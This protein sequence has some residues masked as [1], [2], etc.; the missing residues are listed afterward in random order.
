MHP[1]AA[2]RLEQ[3]GAA[4]LTD[5]NC[6]RLASALE[7][8]EN[9]KR[10]FMTAHERWMIFRWSHS[11][12]ARCGSATSASRFLI[13]CHRFARHDGIPPSHAAPVG[14][15]LRRVLRVAE[16]SAGITS[17]RY[18]HHRAELCESCNLRLAIGRRRCGTAR[19]RLLVPEHCQDLLDPPHACLGLL[20][21][22]AASPCVQPTRGNQLSTLS[23]WPEEDGTNRP[24]GAER[25]RGPGESPLGPAEGC[26]VM[27]GERGWPGPC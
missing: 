24:V 14:R 10:A 21:A 5:T 4:D 19:C 27:T 6:F 15:M 20:H 8:A 9:S 12:H 2:Q 23:M 7:L 26:A 11:N 3:L 18:S 22:L 17:D 25:D 13:S 1:L 16:V